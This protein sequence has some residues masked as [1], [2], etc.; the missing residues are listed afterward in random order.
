MM[1]MMMMMMMKMAT[2]PTMIMA[3]GVEKK[4]VFFEGFPF[5]LDLKM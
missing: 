4:I 5:V 1:M 3:E 2:M